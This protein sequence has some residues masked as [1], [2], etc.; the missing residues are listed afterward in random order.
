PAPRLRLAQRRI[1]AA[2]GSHLHAA[3]FV[4]APPVF[5]KLGPPG[6]TK[7]CC[8]AHQRCE[9]TASLWACG[10][11]KRVAHMPTMTTATEVVGRFIIGL[12]APTRLHDEANNLS[13][14][15]RILKIRLN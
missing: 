10:Q 9:R 5:E 6:R 8:L 14:S 1:S 3:I 4:A 12:K 15:V 7:H 11:R 2:Q 13:Q